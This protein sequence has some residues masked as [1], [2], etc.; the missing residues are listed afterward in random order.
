MNFALRQVSV[1]ETITYI[2]TAPENL[3]ELLLVVEANLFPACFNLIQIQWGDGKEIAD[4]Q[5]AGDKLTIPLPEPLKT[6]EQVN[7]HMTYELDLPAIPPPEEGSRPQP[8]GYTSRQ[9]N[10]VDWYPYLP[11]YRPGEG[12]LVHNPW[13][14]G[15]HQ[16]YTV[17]DYD[18]EIR[19]EG[20]AEVAG[21]P[22]VIAASSPA[23]IEGERHI[24]HFEKA[25][26][27]AWSASP[28]YQVV[29]EQVEGVTIQS[30][31]F[32]FHEEGNQAV[33]GYTAAA[34]RLYSQLFGP[35]P[36]DSLSV[37]EADFLDG[38]EYD[39]LFFLS[40][41][42]Y[43]LYQGTPDGYLTTI[44]VHE[45]AHQWWYGL[46]GNDQ[47]LEPWLDEALCTY[48]EELFY[49]NT[50]PELVDW[51]WSF[52]VNYYQP[53]GPVNGTIYEFDGFRSYRDA[54]YL[55]GASFLEEV[56]RQV[57]D[58]AFFAFLQD[59]ATRFAHQIATAQ[60]FFSILQE[61]TSVD[62]SDLKGAYFEERR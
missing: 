24:Y 61:H 17:A 56:R 46:V 1:D 13:Y 21:Q 19:F 38:M 12:W 35:Y 4:Y 53:T 9:A 40:R 28:A 26:S 41:G 20:A 36:H 49:E 31:A 54:V 50:Y 39:G 48:A 14:F 59:Y 62:L 43:N 52:R 11:P 51:W 2:H 58:E 3:T 34:I 44:A 32:V 47:A 23:R 15:E 7:L 5:L 16:V 37:V 42:F 8:F 25:R 33:L 6:G 45:T 57:G 22:I 29:S 60:D 27:F 10:L 30:Y 55:R 18:V